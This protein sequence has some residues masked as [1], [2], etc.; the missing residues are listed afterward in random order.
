MSLSYPSRIGDQVPASSEAQDNLSKLLRVDPRG[1]KDQVA[2]KVALQY[3]QRS[4]DLRPGYFDGLGS[5]AKANFVYVLAGTAATAAIGLTAYAA[6]TTSYGRWIAG[7]LCSTAVVSYAFGY[8]PEQNIKALLTLAI[9]DTAVRAAD[10][11]TKND[12][13]IWQAKEKETKECH[14]EILNQLS[15]VYNDCAKELKK[16]VTTSSKNA[17]ERLELKRIADR[18]EERLPTIEKLLSGLSLGKHEIEG[19]LQ[20]FKDAIRFV[21]DQAC[22]LYPEKSYEKMNA[23]LIAGW[24]IDSVREI[25]VPHSIRDRASAAKNSRI[26]ILDQA[27]GYASAVL[28]GIGTLAVATTAAAILAGFVHAY[29]YGFP[30]TTSKAQDLFTKL[31]NQNYRG[32]LDGVDKKSLAGLSVLAV[33]AVGSSIYVTAKNGLDHA[34]AIDANAEFV[35]SELAAC[36][37]DLRKIYD[38]V[39]THLQSLQRTTRASLTIALSQ[40]IPA[41]RKEMTGLGLIDDPSDILRKL[42]RTLLVL[43]I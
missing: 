8:R 21:Q 13:R 15:A 33:G 32:L 10:S 30:A 34:H 18:L 42:E 16:F 20:R 26:G 43:E 39:A 19:V 29:Q 9:R 31:A 11:S 3:F 25:A 23:D 4:I 35:G 22:R 14:K 40:R 1:G 36:T 38:G 17:N 27:A 5:W 24:S 41:I 12:R 37:E 6:S 7:G 2:T 28:S